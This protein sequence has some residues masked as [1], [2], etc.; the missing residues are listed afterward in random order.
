RAI[1]MHAFVHAGEDRDV[2][3]VPQAALDQRR[4]VAGR[5]DVGLFGADHRPASLRLHAAHG[6][7]GAREAHAHAVAMR[8]L[9]ETVLGR[10]RAEADGFEQD[11][12]A[13]IAWHKSPGCAALAPASFSGRRFP[14]Y[15]RAGQ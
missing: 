12:V 5:V 8:D 14:G 9:E 13:W 7:H 3:V 10:D 2:A 11:I 15:A 4:H 1:L 6:G